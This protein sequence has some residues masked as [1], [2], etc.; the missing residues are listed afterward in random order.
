M[1]DTRLSSIAPP[2]LRRLDKTGHPLSPAEDADI[3]Y[4]KQSLRSK[5]GHN[6]FRTIFP[7][8]C[9]FCNEAGGFFVI[10]L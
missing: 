3:R 5:K 4:Q 9:K 1:V 8:K 7:A 6:I 10:A 2:P